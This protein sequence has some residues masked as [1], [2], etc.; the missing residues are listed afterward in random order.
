[1]NKL[2][3]PIAVGLVSAGAGF[4]AGFVVGGN[5]RAS[6]V[7]AI[8]ENEI[9]GMEDSLKRRYKVA[10][11]AE[12]LQY[13]DDQGVQ[14][15]SVPE[16]MDPEEINEEQL[17]KLAAHINGQGYALT[18]ETP[19]IITNSFVQYGDKK[20]EFREVESPVEVTPNMVDPEPIIIT[21]LEYMQDEEDYDKLSVSWFPG[22]RV[23][24]DSTEQPIEDV[25]GTVGYNN[26]NTMSI[27]ENSVIYIRNHRLQQDFEI[28]IEVGTYQETI[29]GEDPPI[30]E[31]PRRKAR[32]KVDVDE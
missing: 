14:V 13:H 6:E 31:R 18:S 12:P 28:A 26:L 11:Y 29:L 7:W 16:G 19:P 24:V 10:E 25:E 32:S 5:K 2:I 20:V 3:I 15:I 27:S 17:K 21:D 30:M 23:L 4:Y 1:M 9:E 22:D 8:A